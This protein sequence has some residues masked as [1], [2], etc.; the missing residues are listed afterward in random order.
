MSKL[1]KVAYRPI[2]LAASMLA[3]AAAGAVVKQVW[4]RVADEDDAPSALQSEYSLATI[5][6]G[7]AVQGVV[8]AVIKALIDRGGARLFE[9]VTGA[10]PGD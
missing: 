6:A 1:A 5:L 3:G 8:F 2:G 4:R 7:A 10:W 9:R